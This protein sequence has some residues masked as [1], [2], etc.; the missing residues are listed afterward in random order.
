VAKENQ[1]K[2]SARQRYSSLVN[3]SSSACYVGGSG[4]LA[5]Q[6]ARLGA[7]SKHTAANGHAAW[8]WRR[9]SALCRALCAA[10][11]GGD[12]VKGMASGRNALATYQQHHIDIFI[13]K[14][15]IAHQQCRAFA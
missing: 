11:R 12:S 9:I 13:A 6:G 8:R 5:Y 3:I 2:N 7:V 4:S 15:R 10:A 1:T 14:R